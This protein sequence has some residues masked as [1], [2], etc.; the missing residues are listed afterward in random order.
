M[1]EGKQREQAVE[2]C[3]QQLKMLENELKGKSFFGGDTIGYLDIAA[4][5]IAFWFEAVRDV[6][7]LDLVTE[8]R[9]PILCK[10]I[11]KLQDIDVVNECRPPKEKHVNY[12]RARYE[13]TKLLLPT[14]LQDDDL[15][16]PPMF[17]LPHREF[18]IHRINEIVFLYHHL[19]IILL[20]HAWFCQIKIDNRQK[21]TKWNKVN[22]K[23]NI[24]SIMEVM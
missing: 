16:L 1:A 12:V 5:V 9:F 8:E 19:N 2:E 6:V 20:R 24:Y 21:Q 17:D 7:G 15:H 10:W 22:V 4:L 14:K 18:F 3:C 23:N 13:A 11:G